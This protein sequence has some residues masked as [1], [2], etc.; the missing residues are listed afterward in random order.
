VLST[1]VRYATVA[2]QVQAG[3]AARHGKVLRLLLRTCYA[4]R[5]GMAGYLL[6]LAA[7]HDGDLLAGAARAGAQGLDLLHQ[8]HASR[9]GAEH[10][11]LAVQPGGL[12][13]GEEEL[14]AVGVGARVG[15]G[16]QA[17]AG[18]LQLEILVGELLAVDGFA[19]SAVASL[20]GKVLDIRDKK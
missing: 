10:D 15:H 1:I 3:V 6:E 16:Q 11:V 4:G 9:H 14:R 8:V 7:V 20:W 17:G 19:A 13:G 18:V 2:T 5:V 12:H